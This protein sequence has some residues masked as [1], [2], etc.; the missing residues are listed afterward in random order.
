MESFL[1]SW[2]SIKLDTCT[3]DG[4]RSADIL[5]EHNLSTPHGANWRFIDYVIWLIKIYF[6][7]DYKT[8]YYKL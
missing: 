7:K 5:H 2:T 6:Y 4:E 1:K 8:I 3:C